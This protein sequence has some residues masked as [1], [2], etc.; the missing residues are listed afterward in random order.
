MNQRV[1]SGTTA[2]R[3]NIEVRGVSEVVSLKVVSRGVM[4]SDHRTGPVL[5]QK[6]VRD[7]LTG[8][9]AKHR[10]FKLT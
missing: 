3:N 9:S 7:N 4:T 2:G 6:F 8:L 10:Y 5:A 1:T